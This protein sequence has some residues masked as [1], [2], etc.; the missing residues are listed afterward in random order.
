MDKITFL[1]ELREYLHVLEDNEQE[2]ILEEYSQHIDMKRQN[3]LSEEEAIRDFGSIKELAA[4][5]LQAYHVKLENGVEFKGAES[6]AEGGENDEVAPQEN[7]KTLKS[8]AGYFKRRRE[9]KGRL[10]AAAA[11]PEGGSAD[12]E[13][14]GEK[15]GVFSRFFDF[16]YRG[17]KCA[18]RGLWRI[19]KWCWRVVCNVFWAALSLFCALAAVFLLICFGTLTVLIFQ[20]YPFIGFWL[21]SLGGCA[22]FGAICCAAFGQIRK[23]SGTSIIMAKTAVEAQNEEVL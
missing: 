3:G 18:C 8:I 6:A 21:M 12:V 7:E 19:I 15:R 2:D 4:D 1:A 5:I 16:I 22:G 9:R 20:G 10:N 11:A 13:C 23:K 17:V 14:A